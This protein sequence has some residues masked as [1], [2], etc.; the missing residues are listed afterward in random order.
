MGEF[1]TVRLT[2]QKD[3]TIPWLVWSTKQNEVIASGE[4]SGWDQLSELA[5]YAQQRQVLALVSASDV[6]L[7][8]AEIPPGAERQLDSM[9]PYLLEDDIAQDVDDIHFSILSKK[10][11]Q[12]SVCGVDS[13][14]LT[15]WLEVCKAAGL[16]VKKVLPDVLLLPQKDSV[17][18]AVK[19]TDD[20]LI[21][22]GEWSGICVKEAWLPAVAQ[23]DWVKEEG[24][25][26]DLHAYSPLPELELSENQ[27]WQQ[28]EPMLVM[29][30]LTESAI[31]SKINLLSG[32]FKAKSSWAKHWKLW[33]KAAIAAG[34]FVA[35]SAAYHVIQTSQLEKQAQAYRAESERIFR[36]ALPG[37]TRIP[38]VS[39]L[40]REME[41]EA[42][43]LS[44]GRSG[45]SVLDWLGKLPSS[46][47]GISDM[48]VQNIRFD[49]P[50]GEVRI[51]A[52]SKDFQSFEKA[53]AQLEAQF[54]VEQGQLNRSGEVVNGSF[55]LKKK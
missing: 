3:H 34:V 25:Y 42:N 5:S 18:S 1:L 12:V 23:S 30:M 39:Y 35:V 55:V 24:E 40:K 28:A 38:T 52:Q 14:L 27:Q 15:Q 53:R 54:E 41:T 37:K 9:L 31:A 8:Q 17:L 50:R 20:W 49:A 44:G 22:K 32:S 4:V 48:Q 7:T 45:E 29:Q 6:V 16:D 19:L 11:K 33:Q 46:L 51:Q 36:Q 43:L 2:S 47:K 10:D 21:R 13:A 26:L